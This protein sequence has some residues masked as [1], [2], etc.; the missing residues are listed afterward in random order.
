MRAA[1]TRRAAART[2]AAAA[3][4]LLAAGCSGGAEAP[5]ASATASAT[6]PASTST[7]PSTSASPSTAPSA[8]ASASASASGGTASEAPPAEQGATASQTTPGTGSSA[9]GVVEG[10]PTDL[11]PVLPGA[12]VTS[13]SAVPVGDLQ[14]VSLTAATTAP[15]EEVL[16]FYRERLLAAG[17]AETPNAQG[18]TFTRGGGQ[19]DLRVAVVSAG[20]QQQFTVGGTIA[21][22]AG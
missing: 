22:A 14:Q 4:L 7:A 2:A 15:A 18:A 21:P 6:S 8:S 17:F 9:G 10:F 5:E 11:V 16:A 3:A 13:T 19:E 20:G 1:R 12:T